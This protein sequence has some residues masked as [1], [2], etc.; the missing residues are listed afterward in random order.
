M[1]GPKVVVVAPPAV[2]CL[3]PQHMAYGGVERDAW[4]LARL[5]AA[6][7]CEIVPVASSDSNFGP[8]I[9]ARGLCGEQAWC[10][11]N[12]TTRAR[13]EDVP[14]LL[15]SY[16][17]HAGRVTERE[18]P[19]VILL[20]GPNPQVLRAIIDATR[21]AVQRVIVLLCNGPGDNHP[22]VRFLESEPDVKI[23]CLSEAQRSS[24][25]ALAN[26]IEVVTNGIPVA[27]VPFSPVPA[28]S[29][30]WVIRSPALGGVRLRP[31]RPLIGQIDYFHPNKGMLIT[32][33]IFRSSGMWRTHDLVL[34]GGMGWQLPSRHMPHEGER[35]LSQMRALIEKNDLSDTVQILGALPGWQVAALYGCMD[36][37]ISPVRLEHRELWSELPGVLDPESYGQGRA[38][39]NS[40]GTPVLMSDKYDASFTPVTHPELRFRDTADGSRR[41]RHL[42]STL[43]LRQEMRSFA[44]RRDVMMP[45]LA[46][47]VRLIAERAEQSRGIRFDPSH[48]ALEHA[49]AQLV[50]L[51]R[52]GF[53]R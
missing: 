6:V 39:A 4:R 53:R 26:R 24:F 51:E 50:S 9:T 12:K 5:L 22:V 42:A 13:S 17:R 21:P 8:G 29:R 44:E 48:L 47:Y 2:A 38:I 19:D 18:E 31:Q 7:G 28:A 52:Q 45:G 41:V 46:R 40:A 10:Q 37:A 11:E 43:S 35:Y 14:A 32:L 15:E 36:M 27:A 25:G 20:L 3:N 1:M 16:A 23:L 30:Y 49:F 33:E 34:A